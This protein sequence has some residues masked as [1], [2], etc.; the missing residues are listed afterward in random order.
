LEQLFLEEPVARLVHTEL[1]ATPNLRRE[2]QALELEL[3][4][5]RLLALLEGQEKVGQQ[6]QEVETLA[7]MAIFRLT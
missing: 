7:T 5:L 1:V 6:A 2:L 4:E 3:V